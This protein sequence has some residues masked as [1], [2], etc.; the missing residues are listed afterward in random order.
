MELSLWE[1]ITHRSN[2]CG[3]WVSRNDY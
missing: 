1:I 2:W 3:E